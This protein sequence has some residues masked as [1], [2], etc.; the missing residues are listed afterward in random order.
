MNCQTCEAKL[1]TLK[2]RLTRVNEALHKLGLNYH[3]FLPVYDVDAALVDNGFNAT[4]LWDSRIG[5]VTR[6]HEEVGEGKWVTV[7]CTKMDS[8]RWELVAYVN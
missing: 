3:N 5:D 2:T 6:I 4:E 8:G 7:V 1:P